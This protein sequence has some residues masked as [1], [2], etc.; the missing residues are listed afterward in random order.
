MKKLKR[1]LVV[2]L[3]FFMGIALYLG[4]K[5]DISPQSVWEENV[6]VPEGTW[7]REGSELVY[8]YQLPERKDGRQWTLLLQTHWTDYQISSNNKNIYRRKSQREGAVHLFQVAGGET[9]TV[10]FFQVQKENA[11]TAIQK[12]R[13]ALGSSN[14]MYRFLLGQNWYAAFFA[15]FALVLGMASIGVGIYI[16][17]AWSKIMCR[18]LIS[19]GLYILIAGIWILTDSSLLLLVTQKTGVIELIS[20]LTFFSIPFPL[21]EF[22]KGMFPEKRKAVSVFQD[23]FLVTFFVYLGNYI[24]WQFSVSGIITTEHLFMTATIIF[25]LYT[26]IIELRKNRDCK[27]F[28]IVLGYFTFGI[29]SI[30]ALGFF[31]RGNT[32]SYSVAYMAGIIGFIFFLIDAV[33][34]A[35]Y[36][37]IRENEEVAAYAKMAYLD[38]MTGLGNRTAFLKEKDEDAGFSGTMAYIMLDA[39]NL[40]KTNDTLGHQKGDELIIQI[41]ECIKKAAGRAGRC[42]RIGGDEFVIKLKGRTE[43]EVIAYTEAIRNEIKSADQNSEIKISAAVGYAWTAD[44]KKDLENLMHRADEAM[45]EN[46][47]AVKADPEKQ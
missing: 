39:N 38:L 26:G 45:Y 41:A 44:Q 27:L 31:Y 13:F 29:C 19:L 42:Y 9:L 17:H 36:E 21:L 18:N 30:L 35:T 3:M 2:L 10:R 4:I 34:I 1:A 12:S 23:L 11:V 8:K 5:S 22:T 46:K 20:F 37:Q 14:S 32:L 15:V 25:M 33:C 6:F 16:R 7:T 28:R 40:K 47:A 24:G 43:Q